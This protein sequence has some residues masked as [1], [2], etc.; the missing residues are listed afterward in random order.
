V[1]SVQGKKAVE[2]SLEA[3]Q[4]SADAQ[5]QELQARLQA[6]QEE[7]SSLKEQA[8]QLTVELKDAKG[9]L[10]LHVSA[11]CCVPPHPARPQQGWVSAHRGSC[12]EKGTHMSALHREK[13]MQSTW[14]PCVCPCLQETEKGQLEARTRTQATG[15]QEMEAKLKE[16]ASELQELQRSLEVRW[17][18]GHVARVVRLNWTSSWNCRSM[19][20]RCML[21]RRRA[22]PCDLKS[23]WGLATLPAAV[24]ESVQA[25][26]TS[27][28]LLLVAGHAAA[29]AGQRGSST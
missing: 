21:C 23:S 25:H 4:A 22:S 20:T 3:L 17:E 14:R 8:K 15:M 10:E 24:W 5:Q 27:A 19:R 2:A 28:C 9:R 12:S 13:M 29:A 26:L 18:G 7:R 11:R 6:L 16:K 1:V